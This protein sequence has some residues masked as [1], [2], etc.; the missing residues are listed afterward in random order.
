MILLAGEKT[1]RPPHSAS[2][3]GAQNTE[4]TSAALIHQAVNLQNN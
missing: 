4:A 2:S 1:E 3:G